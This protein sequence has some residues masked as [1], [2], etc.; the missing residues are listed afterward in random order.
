[1]KV[2]LQRVTGAS[3]RV[4]DAL[5]GAIGRGLVVLVGV[6]TGDTE[7]EARQMAA[8]TADLRIFPD[9]AGK[10]NLSAKD[11]GGELL[12]VSQFTLLADTRK[13]KRPSF[14][15][16]APPD[17]AERLFALFVATAGATGLKVATGKFQAHMMVE[18]V[19]DGPV[20]VMLD[21]RTPAPELEA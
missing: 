7:K 19:N 3:V 18:L 6:A 20:T 5:V 13:G 12:I 4:D 10:F 11:V 9:S 2:L 17:E 1:V 14:T 16:A 15:G 8:K 21:S